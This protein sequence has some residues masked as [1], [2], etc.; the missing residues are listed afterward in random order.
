MFAIFQK[1]I[2]RLFSIFKMTNEKQEKIDEQLRP[3]YTELQKFG[4]T[5][6]WDRALKV[7]RKSRLNEF[8]LF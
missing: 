1:K 3:L 7:T 6:D 4:Q 8:I 5:Q 2:S